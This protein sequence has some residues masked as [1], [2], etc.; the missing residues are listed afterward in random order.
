MREQELPKNRV[1]LTLLEGSLK[2]KPSGEDFLALALA[3]VQSR[4]CN[5]FKAFG[6]AVGLLVTGA[7]L[8]AWPHRQGVL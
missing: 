3:L 7:R 4:N 1:Q 6:M 2:D 8:L 5:V